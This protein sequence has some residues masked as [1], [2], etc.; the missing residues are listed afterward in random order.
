MSTDSEIESFTRRSKKRFRR[1]T[2]N[3]RLL[4][5]GTIKK[6]SNK[7]KQIKTQP[8]N[9]NQSDIKRVVL[10]KKNLMTDWEEE[11]PV[12]KYTSKKLPIPETNTSNEHYFI[13]TQDETRDEFIV[14]MR[15]KPYRT[16][17]SV[18]GNEFQGC[19]T[20]SI[21]D[22]ERIG[23]NSM[24]EAFLNVE[25][26]ERCNITNDLSRG[27]GTITLLRTAISF[28]FTYF[29]IDKFIFK[30]IS[31]FVCLPDQHI[32]LPALYLLKHGQS[33]YQKHIHS[34][35]FHELTLNNIEN[36][37]AFVMKKQDWDFLYQ[38]YISQ[39]LMVG[40]SQSREQIVAVL[41]DAWSRTNNYKEFILDVISDD[42]QCIYLM[43]WF[44]E[45]FDDVV[46]KY[47]YRNA[48]NYV[49]YNEF[50]FIKGLQVTYDVI[51]N[52]EMINAR[53]KNKRY[54]KGGATNDTSSFRKPRQTDI[55]VTL[56]EL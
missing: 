54:I 10:S 9:D 53:V 3:R 28:A 49:L 41:H 37:K 48:D 39:K 44:N 19:I 6:N 30:D 14:Y 55:C 12:Y 36:Y 32:S 5:R 45:I 38:T 15:T 25:Y 18:G 43:D 26:N 8:I 50:P 17:I 13:L 40:E 20:I 47:I 46:D 11:I 16:E 33:W 31:N 22:V 23:P 1:N 21:L 52:E 56:K 27:E 7:I 4:K 35:I 29:K 24:I 51:A 2:V 34:R 42:S